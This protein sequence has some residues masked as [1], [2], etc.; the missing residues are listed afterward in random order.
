MNRLRRAT[1]WESSSQVALEIKTVPPDADPYALRIARK[2]AGWLQA[3]GIDTQVTPMSDEELLRQVLVRNEFDLFVARLPNQTHSPDHL[4]SLLHSQFVD[5]RGWQNPFGYANLAVDDLLETQRQSSGTDR[6]AAIE[7][8]QTTMAR[9]QPFTVLAVPDAIRAAR[10]NRY[11]NWR[12]VD[13]RSPL[14]YLQLDR[15]GGARGDP[16]RVRAT[17]T[18]ERRSVLRLVVTDGR[19]TENLNPLS[20][21]FRRDGLL[22]G[23]IYDALGS[24][25]DS[26]TIAPWLADSW[27]FQSTDDGGPRATVR[28]RGDCTWHDGTPLTAD[29]VAFTYSFLTDTTMGETGGGDGTENG[30]GPIPAPRFQGRAGL[31]N[32]VRATDDETVVF[33]FTDCRPRIATRAFTVPI[34]PEHVWS[35]RTETASF[36]GIEVGPATDAL[37]TNNIPPVGSGPLQFARNTPGESLVLERF[38]NH[39]LSTDTDGFPSQVASGPD[40]D[41]LSVQ[42]A[43]SDALAVEFVASGEA[44]VIGTAVGADAVPRIGREAALDLLVSRATSPFVVGYNARRPPLTNPRFRHT[45]GQLIDQSTVVA[46]VFQGYATP[47]VSPLAGSEWVPDDLRWD[48]ANPVVPFLGSDGELDDDRVRETFRATG[49]RYDSG[50]LMERN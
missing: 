1:G 28:L 37:V 32:D 35:D 41:R 5:A 20:V 40:F 11:E 47:A 12:S 7:Q 10:S 16:E 29:D 34:L 2:V 19:P 27:W 48:G 18:T 3:A 44:D 24:H 36:G 25:S 50:K 17:S 14:G 31:V 15:T 30:D 4:H 26:E 38:E 42:V 46:D 13:L 43:G 21:E 23:L 8:L 39:F 33:D 6:R 49:Y 22:T 9:T 45:L